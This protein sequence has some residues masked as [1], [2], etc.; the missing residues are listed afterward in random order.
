MTHSV[1]SSAVQIDA[2]C[3]MA[4]N[5]I[6]WRVL[7]KPLHLFVSFT[8]DQIVC[9]TH[10]L[11]SVLF[12]KFASSP[13]GSAGFCSTALIPSQSPSVCLE[14]LNCPCVCLCVCVWLCHLVTCPFHHYHQGLAPP[15]GLISNKWQ[16]TEN[17]RRDS[18]TQIFPFI[19]L[20]PSVPPL[21]RL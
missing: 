18:L 3:L 19:C 8:F 13:S 6:K 4:G 20:H 5:K 21:F 12:V 16:L 2:T 9:C 14:T 11:G 15:A 17:G 10:F 7:D 1:A